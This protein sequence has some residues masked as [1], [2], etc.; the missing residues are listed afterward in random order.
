MSLGP[1]ACLDGRL[2]ALDQARLP[3]GDRGLLYGDGVFEVLR[4]VAGRPID[5]HWHLERLAQAAVALGLPLVPAALWRDELRAT[6]A[7]TTVGDAHVRLLFTRG[8]DPGGGVA[9]AAQPRPTRLIVARPI[10]AAELASFDAPLDAAIVPQ[11]RDPGHARWKTLNMLPS[12]LALAE[13]RRRGAS[14]ALMCGADGSVIEA[15][16]A[17][18]F[19]VREGRLLT[20]PI[21]RGALDGITRRRVIALAAAGGLATTERPLLPDEVRSADEAFLTSSIRGIVALRRCDGLDLV[22]GAPGPVTRALRG[23]YAAFLADSANP[24][25]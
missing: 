21:A 7:L 25:L 10:S 12:V 8:E 24:E 2:M 1:Q 22:G 14:T 18:L 11:H 13:A 17:N 23:R 19:V 6:L 4:A 16:T 20:P 5:L 3:V 9:P 15:A